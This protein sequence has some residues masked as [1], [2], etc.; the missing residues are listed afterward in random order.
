LDPSLGPE[1]RVNASS[2]HNQER[3]VH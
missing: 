1:L 2:F 3:I